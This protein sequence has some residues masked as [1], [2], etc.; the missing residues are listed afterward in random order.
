MANWTVDSSRESGDV[1]FVGSI[2]KFSAVQ[3]CSWS[4]STLCRRRNLITLGGGRGAW[5]GITSSI[6]SWPAM[7]G[8]CDC[9]KEVTCCI[10][11]VM[12]KSNVVCD[13]CLL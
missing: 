1:M 11:L 8:A 12:N 4:G 3:C 7:K 5:K 9:E 6:K 13:W 2:V 10:F